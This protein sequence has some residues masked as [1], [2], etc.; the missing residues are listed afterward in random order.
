MTIGAVSIEELGAVTTRA[1]DRLARP[2][3]RR[4]RQIN[5]RPVLDLS[6]APTPPA[7]DQHDPP[8]AMREQL[9]LR[10]AHCVFPGC[11]RDSRVCDL[12]HI[13]AYVPIDRRRTTRPD[14]AR[15]SR[16]AVPKPPPPQDPHRLGL[17]RTRRTRLP[18]DRTHRTPIQGHPRLPPATR[19]TNEEPDA[20]HPGPSPAG[21]IARPNPDHRNHNGREAPPRAARTRRE[22]RRNQRRTTTTT[23]ENPGAPTSQSWFRQAQPAAAGSRPDRGI[24]RLCH[25]HRMS[26]PR[27]RS[28]S[29]RRRWPLGGRG[30]G[31]RGV[32]GGAGGGDRGAAPAGAVLR[33]DLRTSTMV[34]GAALGAIALGAWYGG[35]A[36]NTRSPRR[37]WPR[38][39]RR[40]ARPWR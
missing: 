26:Q 30:A 21:D 38:C 36:A 31:V 29:R 24:R 37:A 40:R 8:A 13:T 11:R 17:Q 32:G 27:S 12:D 19:P 1:A 9:M 7:V 14:N 23:P 28:R 18:L 3:L 16:A 10:D 4:R 39:C 25:D 5:L 22:R 15:K 33:P 2:A 35:K 6:D 34:I 20:P